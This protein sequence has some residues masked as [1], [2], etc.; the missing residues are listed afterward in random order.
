MEKTEKDDEEKRKKISIPQSDDSD[1]EPWLDESS[2]PESEQ[3]EEDTA[4]DPPK[5]GQEKGL[6]QNA[7]MIVNKQKLV[8]NREYTEDFAFRNSPRRDGNIR[9]KDGTVLIIDDHLYSMTLQTTKGRPKEEEE[10][11]END[12]TLPRWSAL[13][14]RIQR[15]KLK[16]KYKAKTNI[17]AKLMRSI[18]KRIPKQ[19]HIRWEQPNSV[20]K[21]MLPQYQYLL[22]SVDLHSTYT[23]CYSSTNTSSLVSTSTLYHCTIKREH[24]KTNEDENIKY[25]F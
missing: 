25:R 24:R 12:P 18:R 6:S 3:E 4:I 17:R 13:L 23:L 1:N 20:T 21:N 5:K 2:S 14:M 10:I 7:L 15:Q 11:P 9:M 16:M 22:M 8:V 19:E